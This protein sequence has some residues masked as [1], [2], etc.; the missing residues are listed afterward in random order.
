VKLVEEPYGEDKRLLYLFNGA[1]NRHLLKLYV[2]LSF[3]GSVLMI[4]YRTILTFG[5]YHWYSAYKST[6]KFF[7]NNV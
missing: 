1:Y 7:E 4:Y 2:L 5:V 3:I 6:I